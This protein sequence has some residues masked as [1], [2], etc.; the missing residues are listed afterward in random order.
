M[1]FDAHEFD[2]KPEGEGVFAV[3]RAGQPIGVFALD[4]TGSVSIRGRYSNV[5]DSEELILAVAAAYLRSREAINDAPHR[6][7][8]TSRVRLRATP[9]ATGVPATSKARAGGG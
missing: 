8:T 1:M 3:W 9:A 4:G 6:Q 2:V 7:E 5:D